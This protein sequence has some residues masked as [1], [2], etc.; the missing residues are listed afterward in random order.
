M[1]EYCS[2]HS[3]GLDDAPK[4][5]R[6]EC[7]KKEAGRY[8]ERQVFQGRAPHVG[9]GMKAHAVTAPGILLGSTFAWQSADL[10][11]EGAGGRGYREPHCFDGS[12]AFRQSLL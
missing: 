7:G 8:C 4:Q 1:Q 6:C 10:T 2:R 12:I 5:C 11:A 3:G 9:A